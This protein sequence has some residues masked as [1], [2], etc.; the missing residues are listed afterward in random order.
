MFELKTQKAFED[1]IQKS[2]ITRAEK[3]FLINSIK[4][5]KFNDYEKI[6]YCIE[7]TGI[8]P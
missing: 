5:L 4:T 7:Y 2:V 6:A 8:K 1:N 3:A